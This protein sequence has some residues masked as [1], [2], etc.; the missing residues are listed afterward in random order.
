MAL[1]IQWYTFPVAR[2]SQYFHQKH[3]YQLTPTR[4]NWRGRGGALWEFRAHLTARWPP[5]S[6]CYLFAHYITLLPSRVSP[7]N[8]HYKCRWCYHRFAY[9]LWRRWRIDHQPAFAHM[10]LEQMHVYAR[11]K[12]W[13]VKE[14]CYRDLAV[15]L[16]LADHL[17]SI[18]RCGCWLNYYCYDSWPTNFLEHL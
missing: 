5:T 10:F 11:E 15:L 16:V 1:A 7:A 3:T 6:C 9:A 13:T 12:W 2:N 8:L 14:P 17:K 4:T 18:I